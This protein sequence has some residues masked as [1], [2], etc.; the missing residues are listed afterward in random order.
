MSDY[1]GAPVIIQRDLNMPTTLRLDGSAR[2]LGVGF[3]H[4]K[5]GQIM[6][7]LSVAFSK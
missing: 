6:M 3:S 5:H 4:V 2:S 7:G 1:L